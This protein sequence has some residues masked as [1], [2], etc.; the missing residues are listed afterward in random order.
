MLETLG[1]CAVL[2]PPKYLLCLGVCGH[3]IS[4]APSSASCPSSGTSRRVC[5]NVSWRDP[6]SRITHDSSLSI[7]ARSSSRLTISDSIV[8]TSSDAELARSGGGAP[9]ASR[10]H[11][12]LRIWGG[13]TL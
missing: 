9:L 1:L 10:G 12:S 2:V 8:R 11:I 13:K 5:R 3:Q 7:S 4:R 6:G